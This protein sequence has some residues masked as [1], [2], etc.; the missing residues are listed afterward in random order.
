MIRLL[1]QEEWSAQKREPLQVY[2]DYKFVLNEAIK[3]LTEIPVSLADAEFLRTRTKAG[4]MLAA[5]E[6]SESGLQQL[7]YSYSA[8]LPV[9]DLAPLLPKT[10]EYW[11]SHS[12]HHLAFHQSPECDGHLV[13]H[14][15]LYDLT[16][17][18]AL[19]L[20]CFSILL[21]H[22]NLLGRVM[23]LLVYENDD[24][25]A[26][27]E[28]LVAPYLP[29]RPGSA[30]YTCQLPYRKTKKIFA[31]V[32][33][34]RAELMSKCLD[35]WYDASRRELY[36]DRQKSSGFPGY[37]SL[38]AG[39]ITFILGIDDASYR[40][41]KFYPKDLV[42]Y[43]R[44]HSWVPG[45]VGATGATST[46]VRLRVEAGQPC[47]REGFWLTPAKT[48]SRRLFKAGEVMPD[49]GGD[50]GATIWQWDDKQ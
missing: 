46:S 6:L 26:L 22:P 14:I 50:Y 12:Q 11:E 33:D 16:Y 35:E 9:A 42:D 2:K 30:I 19:Q 4:L 20:V 27:L 49:V 29:G 3:S 5:L 47:P 40:D 31:A 34:K 36:Y 28:A 43:A 25:D 48:N 1:T 8:G 21:G 38:E 44:A 17:W 45:G 15:D 23:E 7:I 10:V 32:P 24:Q 41:K 13:P 37:W 39:A 18:Y